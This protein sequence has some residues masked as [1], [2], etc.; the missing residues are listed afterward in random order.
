MDKELF[1]KLVESMDQINTDLHKA[2]T[3]EDVK[4]F[5][6]NAVNH[7]KQGEDMKCLWTGV[8][9]DTPM[10]MSCPCPKCSIYS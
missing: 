3:L 4:K 6:E 10:S 5:M 2:P 7:H 1:K 9:P 8:K